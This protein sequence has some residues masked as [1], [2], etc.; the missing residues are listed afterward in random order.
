MVGGQV[1]QIKVTGDKIRKVGCD[2]YKEVFK[3]QVE[4]FVFNLIGNRKLLW[5]FQQYVVYLDFGLDLRVLEVLFI[6]IIKLLWFVFFFVVII[7]DF[8][9]RVLKSF[10]LVFISM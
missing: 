1:K 4:Q 9:I 7:F 10:R 8:K 3:R 6:I 2:Y 5:D